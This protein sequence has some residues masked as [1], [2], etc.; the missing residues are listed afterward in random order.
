MLLDTGADASAATEQGDAAG[1]L[2]GGAHCSLP[3]AGGLPLR[4]KKNPRKKNAK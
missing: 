1:R 3:S 2:S 4:L